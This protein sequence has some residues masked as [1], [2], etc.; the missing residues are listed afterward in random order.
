[1]QKCSYNY[2]RYTAIVDSCDKCGAKVIPL[3]P[4][5]FD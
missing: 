1:M 2:K 3:S 4:V 5:K